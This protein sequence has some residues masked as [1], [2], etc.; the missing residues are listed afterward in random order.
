MFMRFSLYALKKIRRKETA[1]TYKE[2]NYMRENLKPEINLSGKNQT[3]I[4][5]K[6]G[7]N[8]TEI[9]QKSD[10]NQAEI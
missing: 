10:R 6:S 7:K 1:I 2:T 4:R 8:Q 3:E 5:Q 9:R